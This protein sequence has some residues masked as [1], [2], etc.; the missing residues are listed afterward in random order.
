MKLYFSGFNNAPRQQAVAI[1]AANGR[2]RGDGRFHKAPSLCGARQIK[3][4]GF[5]KILLVIEFVDLD[6]AGNLPPVVR[7]LFHIDGQIHGP[8]DELLLGA[9]SGFLHQ[10]FQTLQRFFSAVR[11]K[12]A[13]PARMP[14][15]SEFE[16]FQSSGIT[17]F[18]N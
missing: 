1:P 11:V 15:I 9:E 12:G 14:G 6:D 10:F 16:H 5:I 7:R 4:F 2:R 18:T 13:D 3:G 17:H 8:P